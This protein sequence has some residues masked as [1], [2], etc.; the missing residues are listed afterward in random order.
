MG[1]QMIE[2]F[3]R[4]AAVVVLGPVSVDELVSVENASSAPLRGLDKYPR[5]LMFSGSME[6]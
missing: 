4:N 3:L 1:L 2:A 5:K 6:N